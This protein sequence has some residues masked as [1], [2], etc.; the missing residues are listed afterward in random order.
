MTIAPRRLTSFAR[1]LVLL[2]GAAVAAPIA[3]MQVAVLRFG[4]RS[5]L[6]G[7]PH[8]SELDWERIKAA[9]T[10]RLSDRLLADLVVRAGLTVAWV[11]IG[12]FLLTVGLETAHMLR[13]QGLSRPELRGL[14]PI[15]R[16]AR[17][18]AAGLIAL[19]PGALMPSGAHAEL[20]PAT[21][22]T[23]APIGAPAWHA[24]RPTFGAEIEQT[25]QRNPESPPQ[26]RRRSPVEPGNPG[27]APA[28]YVVVAGDSVYAIATRIAGPDTP[29]VADLADQI[30]ELNLGRQ[31]N[32]GQHFTNAAYIEV[33]WELALPASAPGESPSVGFPL[34]STTPTTEHLVVAGDTLS[35]ISA[36]ELGDSAR[37]PELFEANRNRRFG[38]GRTFDDPSL[39]H[40]GWN[41]IIPSPAGTDA[42]APPS[43]E[44]AS[45]V[46]VGD[47]GGGVSEATTEPVDVTPV[48][49][50]TAVTHDAHHDG[51]GV[52]DAGAAAVAPARPTNGWLTEPVPVEIVAGNHVVDG[53]DG[54]SAAVLITRERATMLAAGVVVVLGA[55]RRRRLREA[56]P[57]GRIPTPPPGRANAERSLRAAAG[58]DRGLRVEAL[59]V[60]VAPVLVERGCRPSVLICNGDGGVELV[61][62]EPVEL[63]PPWSRVG[64]NA[65]ARWSIDASGLT[66]LLAGLPRPAGSPA[67]ALVQLGVDRAGRHVYVDLEALETLQID[68]PPAES[69]S[70]VA[71][72][73]ATLAGSVT[74]ELTTLISVDLPSECFLGRRS[75][76]AAGDIEEALA[77]AAGSVGSTGTMGKGTFELRAK[78]MPGETWEP[79]IVL[80]GSNAGRLNVPTNRSGL[81]FVSAASMPG[82]KSRLVRGESAWSLDPVGIELTPIGLA[83]DDISEL[84]DLLGAESTPVADAFEVVT[85]RVDG[86]AT[87]YVADDVDT[88]SASEPVSEPCV[89]TDQ[90]PGWDLLVRVL[91]PVR[92]VDAQRREAHFERSKTTELLAWLA[93][94]RE[95]STR[96]NARTA[97]WE[98]DV[99]DATFANVVSEARRALARLV[100]PAVGE[101]WVARTLTESLPLHSRVVSDADIVEHA[102][103]AARLQPPSQA[104]ATL[105]PAVDLI[106]GMPFE[107]TS[108]LWPDA[109]GLMS[110]LVLLATS[111]AAELAAH[112]L[113]MGDVDGV[114]RATGRGLRVLPGHEQLIALRMR[115]HAGAGDHAGVRLEW[116]SYERMIDGDPWS[117]GEPSPKLVE[118]RRQLLRSSV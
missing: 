4:G 19:A 30:V 33:G 45:A 71:A 79:T 68:G 91:G 41:L 53:V 42:Q 80:V 27:G 100:A 105:S 36:T 11:A 35:S 81:A 86:A 31:M 32:D 44:P 15:Q 29:A 55:R 17:L 77:L 13:H 39:I 103:R 84:S 24:P 38:D 112:C 92:V 85:N 34:A 49:V 99:R 64:E 95:R 113:S 12:V 7:L 20:R 101:E 21:L 102:V 6:Y 111:A 73:A 117:G 61:V 62:S 107:G 97:L 23:S 43:V 66:A 16:L 110:H 94:H 8:L 28:T 96:I 75:H 60:A 56:P 37:W 87:L 72:V 25:R 63:P 65:T 18:V 82:A 98:H 2:G 47:G 115:A 57:R 118:L 26:I 74:G 108:Y 14:R 114:F 106:A 46:E 9:L 10:R 88:S 59:V 78:A 83:P 89:P 52:P 48:E 50:G 67:P 104:V 93:T 109:E 69:N 22:E 1:S 116:E 54:K 5:P 3:L 51:T 90:P 58:D 76:R 40:P 70:I